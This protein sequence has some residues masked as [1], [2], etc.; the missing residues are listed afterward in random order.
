M[1]MVSVYHIL[2][3]TVKRFFARFFDSGFGEDSN[4]KKWG[5]NGKKIIDIVRALIYNIWCVRSFPP[6]AGLAGT[7]WISGCGP[8]VTVPKAIA[9]RRRFVCG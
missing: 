4:G 5:K 7:G 2:F 8:I 1:I 9:G 3:A 6:M